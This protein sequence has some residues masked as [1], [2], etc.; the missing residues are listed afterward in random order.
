MSDYIRTDNS[1]SLREF[2]LKVNSD[3]EFRTS[4]LEDPV[5]VLASAGITLSPKAK[6]EVSE[7]TQMLVERL[8]QI[9]EIPSGFT[10]IIED[11]ADME[12]VGLLPPIRFLL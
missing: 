1:D 3:V 4:F 2:M 6:E 7:V 9:S 10:L 8:P 11:T 12:D 5:K